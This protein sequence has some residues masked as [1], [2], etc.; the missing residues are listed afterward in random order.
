MFIYLFQYKNIKLSFDRQ[1]IQTDQQ[2]GRKNFSKEIIFIYL[3]GAKE[4]VRMMNTKNRVIN[5]FDIS[6]FFHNIV[7]RIPQSFKQF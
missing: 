5:A 6:S 3:F 7:N 4:M 1:H 2:A